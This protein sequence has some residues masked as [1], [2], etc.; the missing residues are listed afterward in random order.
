MDITISRRGAPRGRSRLALAMLSTMRISAAITLAAGLLASTGTAQAAADQSLVQAAQRYEHGEGVAQDIGRAQSL[1]CEAARQG[2]AE[3]QYRLGWMYFNGRGV[4]RDDARAA[5][6]LRMAAEQGHRYAQIALQYVA[7]VQPAK[8]SCLTASAVALDESAPLRPIEEEFDAKQPQRARVIK[9]VQELSPRYG[10]DP[11]LALSVIRAESGFDPQARSPKNAQGLMQLIPETAERFN[12]K[13]VLDPRENIRGGLAYLR[14]LLAT[15]RGDVPL[16]LAA[17]NAGEGAVE[18]HGGIPPFPETR[19]YV[20]RVLT[21]YGKRTHA[22]QET[23]AP[24]SMSVLPR[25]A[26][27]RR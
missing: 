23:A 10:V 15:F 13:N 3:A 19:D 17:Y 18:K 5:A 22:Y 2:D 11:R 12:V 20:K 21:W 27:T 4:D 6:L 14:W 7:N 24:P 26:S 25:V 8:P 16:V 9:I 1:Y